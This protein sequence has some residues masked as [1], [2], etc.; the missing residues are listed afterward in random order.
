V[1]S[2]KPRIVGLNSRELGRLPCGTP[3][4]APLG[5]IPYAPTRTRSRRHLCGDRFRL[6]GARHVRWHDWTLDEYREAFHLLERTSSAAAVVSDKLRRIAIA[7]KG[8][9][10]AGRVRHG[11]AG[12]D[13]AVAF[14]VERLKRWGL[15]RDDGMKVPRFGDLGVCRS[16]PLPGFG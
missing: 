12:R 1:T 15:G 6:V 2:P 5:E 10:S 7:R 13:R 16:H 8:Q 4:L 9:M 11:R 14:F 3:Y